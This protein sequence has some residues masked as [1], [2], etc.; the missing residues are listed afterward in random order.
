MCNTDVSHRR[1]AYLSHKDKIMHPLFWCAL[2]LDSAL[3]HL[4][5]F[6]LLFQKLK[7]VSDVEKKKKNGSSRAIR[8][9]DESGITNMC[10]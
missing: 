2:H 10:Y 1:E 7:K 9:Q 4:T 8:G 3:N 6:Q 5:H